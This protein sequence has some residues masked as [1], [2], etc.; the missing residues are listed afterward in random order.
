MKKMIL[1]LVFASYAAIGLANDVE[2]NVVT[3]DVSNA[4]G[5]A[6]NDGAIVLEGNENLG[7]EDNSTQCA[8]AAWMVYWWWYDLTGSTTWAG[9][10]AQSFYDSCMLNQ[11]PPGDSI[12]N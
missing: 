3:I 11:L 10:A 7:I 12:G 8:A 9:Q 4:C 1:L 5:V 6:L 2:R